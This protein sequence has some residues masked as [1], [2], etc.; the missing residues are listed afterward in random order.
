MH[1]L[2]HITVVLH[3]LK[4]LLQEKRHPDMQASRKEV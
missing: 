1:F 4:D 3:I 2:L